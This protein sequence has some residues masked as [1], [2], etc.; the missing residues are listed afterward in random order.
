[1]SQFKKITNTSQNAEAA[2][3]AYMHAYVTQHMG[4][5]YTKLEVNQICIH[6]N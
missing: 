4:P 3:S 1:M 5:E 2:K 6:L